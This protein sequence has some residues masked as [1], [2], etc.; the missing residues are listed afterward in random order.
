MRALA[1]VAL[2]C[3]AAC[4]RPLTPGERNYADILFG[5]TLDAEPVRVHQGLGLAPPVT[6]V[7]ATV[8]QVQG[9]DTACLRV[10][11]PRGD[12]PP[13]AFALGNGVFLDSSIYTSDAALGWPVGLRLPQALVLA[14]ELTHVWQWQ[15]RDRTGYSALRAVAESWR[16]SDP[17]YAA[18]GAAP[19]FLAFGYEQQAALVEDYICFAYANPGHP[20]R[21]ELR[22]LIDPVIPLDRFDAVVA[23]ATP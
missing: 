16:L 7:P 10:P 14:H 5:D 1:V 20:R 2:C 9:T 21:D 17:Y 15:N 19:D 23:G 13:W 8:R 18:R 4:G 3:L 22:A 12:A 6:T 11:Q